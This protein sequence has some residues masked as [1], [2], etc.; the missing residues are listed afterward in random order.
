MVVTAVGTIVVVTVVT[1]GEGWLVQPATSTAI[2]E[3]QHSRMITVSVF[4][5]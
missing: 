4:M 1:G 2:M 5:Q 3:I